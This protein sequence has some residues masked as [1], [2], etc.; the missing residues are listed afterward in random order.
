MLILSSV[1]FLLVLFA[2]LQISLR[3][4]ALIASTDEYVDCEKDASLV[5][6][7]SDYLTE[8]VR[9]YAMTADKQN[10]LNYFTELNTTRRRELALENLYKYN[11]SDETVDFLE[12]ALDYSNQ[13]AQREIYAMKLVTVAMD[14]DLA[15]FPEEIQ[16]AELSS[17]DAALSSEEKLKTARNMLFDSSYLESKTLISEN[18]TYFLNSITSRM[19]DAQQS[20]VQ[21]LNHTLLIQ[22]ILL[23][24]LFMINALTFALI[25]NLIIKP[26]KIQIRRIKDDNTMEILGSYEFKY[27]ALTYNHIYETNAENE[28][29]LHYKAEHDP[30]TGIMNRGAFNE[31]CEMLRDNDKPMALLLIDVD[32]FKEINDGYGHEVGDKILQKV[33]A[34]LQSSFR[35][36]DFAIRMGG[37]EFC[38]IMLD[39]SP[40]MKPAIKRKAVIIND[41][42]QNPDDD[43]PKTSLSIGVAFSEHGYTDNLYNDT[44]AALY[45]VKEKGRCGCE[46]YN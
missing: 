26:L 18:T 24:I 35:S 11:T 27:L 46:F 1:L 36:N 42:L 28:K 44:D 39:I 19:H 3:Y 20:H 16:N 13:L 29:K 8:Q 22:R 17:E 34:L 32:K 6:S 25:I 33:A 43:L 4:H 45:R 40:E 2:T 30:L 9:L 15:E 23:I 14:Y 7:G 38:V 31:L 37:D 41:L 10:A 5:S 21:E 12:S